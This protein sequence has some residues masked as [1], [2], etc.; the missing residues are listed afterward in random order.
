MSKKKLL[1]QIANNI[2]RLKK[3][4][5]ILVCIDGVDGAGKT[6]FAKD[7][8]VRFKSSDQEII[9][10]SVDNFHNP[11]NIRYRKGK[12]SAEGFYRDSYNYDV[13]KQNLLE[14]FLLGQGE[15]VSEVFDVDL[16]Q[17][18]HSQPQEVPSKS[19]LIVE[20]IFLQRQELNKYWDVKIF[21]DVDFKITLQRN[22]N[23]GTDQE[24]IGSAEKITERYN[25][26]YMPGQE[27]YIREADPRSNADIVIDNNDFQNPKI[28]KNAFSI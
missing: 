24:R 1:E 26:R 10:C 4:T 7:L 23:R 15:Y 11:K 3:N 16:N 27:I 20:G 21:L 28:V 8:A 25:A 9:L 22:I 5:P 13:F 6:Y 2:L 19:I 18:I 14:P 17:T 12:N